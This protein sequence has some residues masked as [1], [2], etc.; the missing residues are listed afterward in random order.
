MLANHAKF[1][2]QMR[3]RL[4]TTCIGLGLVRLLQ[5][6][7]RFAEPKTTLYSLEDG[8][9]DL[10]KKSVKPGRNRC[11]ANQLK[12]TRTDAAKML[13]HPLSIA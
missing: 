3:T 11:K 6:A 4:K 12:G 1:T 8:F 7:R 9:Q 10:A 2:R 5:D 13:T